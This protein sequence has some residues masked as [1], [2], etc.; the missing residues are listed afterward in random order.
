MTQ[1]RRKRKARGAFFTPPEI[2]EFIV[3]WAVRS[4][5]D[6]ILEPSCGQAA[7]L[8]AAGDR[9]RSLS[10]LSKA[11]SSSRL[12]TKSIRTS[13]ADLLRERVDSVYNFR[14][15]YMAY[16]KKELSDTEVARQALGDWA[17][18]LATLHAARL[19]R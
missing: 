14:N 6:T 17:S 19:D 5:D 9:L 10:A 11:E 16:E 3:E 12:R 2:A 7:F 18:T 4:P 15:D 8:I 1:G 13:F